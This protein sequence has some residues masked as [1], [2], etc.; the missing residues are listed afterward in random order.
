MKTIVVEMIIIKV[1]FKFLMAPFS[2][3][4]EDKLKIVILVILSC[5][6]ISIIYF[7]SE[8]MKNEE[9]SF[10]N[11][12]LVTIPSLDQSPLELFSNILHHMKK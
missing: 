7:I 3:I 6:L 10:K 1:N 2:H 11:Y 12:S 4:D 5:S 8:D 9:N